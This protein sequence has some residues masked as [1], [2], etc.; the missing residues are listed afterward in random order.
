MALLET[1]PQ[2]E[3]RMGSPDEACI[4]EWQDNADPMDKTLGIDGMA[5]VQ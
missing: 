2:T 3:V 1:S 4:K 5:V